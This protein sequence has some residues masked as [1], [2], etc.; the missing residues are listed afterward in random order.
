MSG[1]I[2]SEQQLVAG[3]NYLLAHSVGDFLES[4]FIES[5]GVGVEV[6]PEQIEKQ[7]CVDRLFPVL[8]LT[9]AGAHLLENVMN[10]LLSAIT[11]QINYVNSV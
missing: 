1:K 7:V 4:E 10:H 3:I 9:V 5:C 8:I 11:L 2:K 6:T